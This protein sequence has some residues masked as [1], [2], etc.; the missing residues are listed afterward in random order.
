MR[1]PGVALAQSSNVDRSLD[2][3]SAGAN[4]AAYGRTYSED[5]FSPLNQITDGNVSRLHLVSFTDLPPVVNAATAPLEVDGVLYFS[6]GLSVVY[7]VDPR[8]GKVLWSYDP[9]VA[10]VA[11][12]KLRPAWGIRGIAYWAG[13]VY[14]ATQDGRM[15]S[16]DARTGQLI[17][18]VVTT[19][20][21]D[22]RYITGVP[23]AFNGKV[24]IGH[25][26]GDFA[27]TRGYVT[28]YDAR[29]GKQLWRF[30]TV[31]A[32]TGFE[33]K[34]L[35]WAA[36]TWAGQ[37]RRFSAG[38]AVW[39]AITYDPQFNRIYIGT[40][41]A[42]PWNSNL[43]GGKSD[44]LFVCSIVALDAD[45]GRYVWHYQV[46][47]GD[48]WD[49]DAAMDMELATVPIH[50]EPTP[51]LLQAPKNGFFY[52]INRKTGKLLSA[53]KFGHVNWASRVDMRTGRPVENAAAR[54]SKEPYL[55]FPGPGGVHNI[56]AMSYDPLTA[57][58]YI[59]RR[60]LGL[61]YS[62]VGIDAGKWRPA[63]GMVTNTGLAPP[64]ATLV[65]PPGHSDL[66]AWDPLKQ[67]AVWVAPT[68]G[69][70]G[71]G[72]ATTAGNLVFQ[73]QADGKFLAYAAD[74][75]KV[76][77]T[78][79]AQ[80]GVLAQ[81]ITYMI[82]GRQ[83]VSVIA[84]FG[85]ANAAQDAA[86][87]GWDYRTQMRR[88]L[89]FTLDGTAQLPPL[90]ASKPTLVDDPAFRV[91]AALAAAGALTYAEHCIICHG[92]DLKSGGAAPDLRASSIPLSEDAFTN[93]LHGGALTGRG[94]PR[95]E[96][97]SKDQIEGLMHY[98]RSSQRASASVTAATQ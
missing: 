29:T 30:Y 61:V 2:D 67:K 35:D 55:V 59:P 24:I 46:N 28:T 41:N 4:W 84:G 18:S 87:F 34:S 94:M 25:S 81:P 11:G 96:D 51:V 40:G 88:L 64:P 62:S 60:D 43:R 58:V 22:S 92:V 5:H 79:A 74:S 78:F 80:N 75:G 97:F 52:V 69:P 49:F 53:E 33:D 91:D 56:Q 57:L 42:Q 26:G 31:P 70:T 71:S 13:Q 10:Q 45:T 8:S 98:I 95:F 3:E 66:V 76:L 90:S 36:K 38:G 27:P 23:R 82:D 32:S 9:K 19:Q 48:S 72:V 89:T 47:P 12:E 17:W 20:K 50:G 85:G 7:A 93:L 39:N 54:F 63:G 1:L 65:V 83:Y 73:G 16:L 77:W 21:N 68:P 86:A 15:L 6:L 37:N 14:T 44:D